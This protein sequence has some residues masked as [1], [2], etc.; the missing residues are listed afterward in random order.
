VR[1]LGATAGFSRCSHPLSKAIWEAI[2]Q[3][4]EGPLEGGNN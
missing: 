1:E 3:G 4:L 2:T